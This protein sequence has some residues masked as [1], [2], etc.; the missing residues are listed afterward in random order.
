VTRTTGQEE[1]TTRR[2]LFQGYRLFLDAPDHALAK[3]SGRHI[4][5][6]PS[7]NLSDK[8]SQPSSSAV[9]GA[10]HGNSDRF[11]DPHR[12]SLL[13]WVGSVVCMVIARYV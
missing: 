6:H 3:L 5:D 8:P 12:A 9:T 10:G 2:P 4:S 7:V 13:F 11:D 1:K